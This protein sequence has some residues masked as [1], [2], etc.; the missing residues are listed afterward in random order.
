M[1]SSLALAALA[2]NAVTA[3]RQVATSTLRIT[4]PPMLCFKILRYRWALLVQRQLSHRR[5]SFDSTHG[6]HRHV[7]KAARR[8]RSRVSVPC[9]STGHVELERCRY[10]GFLLPDASLGFTSQDAPLALF[11]F[12]YVFSTRFGDWK[13]AQEG[14]RFARKRNSTNFS[15][16]SQRFARGSTFKPVSRQRSPEQA[17]PS[18]RAGSP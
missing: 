15:V 6:F 5:C 10:D 16:A 9:L 7:D 2:P 11:C 12:S 4:K 8:P 14:R 3:A 18:R 1:S 17:T 13:L